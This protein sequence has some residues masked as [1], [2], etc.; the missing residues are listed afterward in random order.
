MLLRSQ[1][2]PSAHLLT[3]TVSLLLI[4]VAFVVARGGMKWLFSS[5]QSSLVST[6]TSTMASN[7]PLYLYTATHLC[8]MDCGR[9]C[10]LTVKKTPLATFSTLSPNE[11]W[12]DQRA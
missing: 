11:K 12:T 1:K 6:N 8:A 10:A 9:F 3:S 2:W 5:I 7:L 4:M